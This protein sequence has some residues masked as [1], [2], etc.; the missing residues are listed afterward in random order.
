MN[1]IKRY[2]EKAPILLK[3]LKIGDIVTILG[4]RDKYD[5]R[6]GLKI[7]E[8]Y[9]ITELDSCSN[10]TWCYKECPTKGIGV[11]IK[12]FNNPS[13]PTCFVVLGNTNG[14]ELT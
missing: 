12:A 6:Y 9:E 4:F 13:H 10:F 5:R 3:D 1:I 2:I 8:K 7:G 11:T 14:K